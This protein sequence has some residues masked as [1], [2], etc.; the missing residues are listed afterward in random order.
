MTPAKGKGSDP[1][2]GG[3]VGEE[4]VSDQASEASEAERT[5]EAAEGQAAAG[6]RV[7]EPGEQA[8]AGV[9]RKALSL[10]QI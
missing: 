3:V 6:A 4:A 9:A 7:S 2:E 1:Q 8:D 10:I 5:D